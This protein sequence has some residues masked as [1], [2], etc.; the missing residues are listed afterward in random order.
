MITCTIV[1]DSGIFCR[2][3]PEGYSTTS[4]QH[5]CGKIRFYDPGGPSQWHSLRYLNSG[6][7]TTGMHSGEKAWCL[8]DARRFPRGTPTLAPIDRDPFSALRFATL[9]GGI[10]ELVRS[11]AAGLTSA[12]V[13]LARLF[14]FSSRLSVSAIGLEVAQGHWQPFQ[15]KLRGVSRRCCRSV[16]PY[17]IG[18]EG[19]SYGSQ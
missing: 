17:A 7:A 15:F 18:L 16:L 19:G 1:L 8:M 3:R 2:V 10:C 6:P 13:R 12:M 9:E 11:V 5:Q 14:R 4:G